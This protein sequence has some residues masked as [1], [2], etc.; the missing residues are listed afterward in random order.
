MFS[1]ASLS[2]CTCKCTYLDGIACR[3]IQC[4]GFEKTTLSVWAE[5]TQRNQSLFHP[6]ILKHR[7]TILSYG[8]LQQSQ[9]FIDKNHEIVFSW[10]AI[11]SKIRIFFSSWAFFLHCLII[12]GFILKSFAILEKHHTFWEKCSWFCKCIVCE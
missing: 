3:P 7:I 2:Q 4:P 10:F 12:R 8:K 6:V 1:S 9:K 5:D 11:F